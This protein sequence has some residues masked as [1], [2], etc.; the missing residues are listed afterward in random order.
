LDFWAG[1][2]LLFTRSFLLARRF[3]GPHHRLYFR[4][5]GLSRRTQEI[6]MDWYNGA[7]HLDET[8]ALGVIAKW[9]A[10]VLFGSAVR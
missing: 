1:E 2:D 6:G 4:L 3:Y 7:C 8:S 9:N 5:A 10:A